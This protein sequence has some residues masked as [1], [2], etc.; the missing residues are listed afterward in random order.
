[1]LEVD[2]A[3]HIVNGTNDAPDDPFDTTSN[4]QLDPLESVEVDSMVLLLAGVPI[5]GWLITEVGT[6]DVD[7]TDSFVFKEVVAASPKHIVDSEFRES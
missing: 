6:V 1:M 2:T 4:V 3:L 7:R 5:D